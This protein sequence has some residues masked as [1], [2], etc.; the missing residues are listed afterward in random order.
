MTQFDILNEET[1]VEIPLKCLI[2]V[3]MGQ[4]T[5]VRRH[6]HSTISCSINKKLLHLC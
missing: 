3:E 5:Q 6:T 1:I 2:T 4:D